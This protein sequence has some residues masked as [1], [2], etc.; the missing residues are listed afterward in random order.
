MEQRHAIK[1]FVK[2]MKTK[3]ETYE[4]KEAYG[5]KQMSQASFY[6]WFNRFSEGYE[7]VEDEP[8]F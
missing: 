5:N 6:W 7:Q 1:L 2:L 8:R 4:I 3:Q